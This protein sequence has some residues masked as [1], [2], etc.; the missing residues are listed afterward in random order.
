VRR[1]ILITARLKST[2]LK[3]KVRK[4]LCGKPLISH[5]IDR[6]KRC[7]GFDEIILCTSP[8]NQDEPLV[9]IAEQE[10]IQ[11]YAGHPD[12][13]LLRLT[14]AAQKF[15]LD[16]VINVTGDNPLIEVPIL[17]QLASHHEKNKF[18]F[19]KVEGI[20]IGT[21]GWGLSRIAMEKA[22]KIKNKSDTE[23]WAEY[24]LETTLFDCGVFKID[25]PELIMDVRLTVDTPADFE[26]IEKIFLAFNQKVSEMD[27]RNIL[28]YLKANPSLVKINK[29]VQHKSPTPIK[30]KAKYEQYR[31]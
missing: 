24:F 10:E 31:I 28:M 22:L 8:L 13:V 18:D 21:Y 20:P 19:T 27:L 30:L 25:D 16:T 12:D 9:E 7:N 14:E 5:L 6:M 23:W 26:L 29:Q 2:R 3:E 11:C 4:D 1:G 17:E 15:N